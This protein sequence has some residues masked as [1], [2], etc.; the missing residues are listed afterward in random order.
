MNKP[1]NRIFGLEIWAKWKVSNYIAHF[2][3]NIR[4][5]FQILRG[6]RLDL[7]VHHRQVLRKIGLLGHLASWWCLWTA[8][9]RCGG[10]FQQTAKHD[11]WIC[12]MSC[13][14]VCIDFHFI[15]LLWIVIGYLLLT[16]FLFTC[17][18]L[19]FTLFINST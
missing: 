10:T 15:T 6:W 18:S 4:R 16:P 13:T 8:K 12:S 9:L 3:E 19:T 1:F 7:W 2:L 17:N 11:V 14:R 5:S